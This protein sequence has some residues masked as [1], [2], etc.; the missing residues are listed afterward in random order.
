M[1]LVLVL[2]G[3][4]YCSSLDWLCSPRTATLLVLSGTKEHLVLTM[5]SVNRCEARKVRI[6]L[7]RKQCKQAKKD[8]I[9]SKPSQIRVSWKTFF[10]RSDPCQ[11]HPHKIER[12]R[13]FSATT[14]KTLL[15]CI[16]EKRI[17]IRYPASDV[18]CSVFQRSRTWPVKSKKLGFWSFSWDH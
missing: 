13:I 2:R 15:A 14:L 9:I 11:T 7:L 6:S 18:E 4:V 12:S 1:S 10:S 5:R 16:A 3:T 17:S 8:D